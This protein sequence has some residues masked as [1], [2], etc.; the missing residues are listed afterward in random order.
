[1]AYLKAQKK[2]YK[3]K[4][5]IHYFSRVS[6][7][8][9]NKKDIYISLN[10]TDIKEARQ[11]HQEVEKNEKA[12]KD[13]EDVQWSWKSDNG[14]T[15][16]LRKILG[17]CVDEWLDAIKVSIRQ[18]SVDR[19][20]CSLNTFI[21]VMGK[22]CPMSAI[23][24]KSIED[25]KRFYLGKHK[26]G[27]IDI[28]LRGIKK[29]LKWSL[30]EEYIKKMPKIKQF[31]KKTPPKYIN[32]V[33]WRKLMRL[34][35]DDYWKNL[36]NLYRDVGSRLKEILEGE[37]DGN[38]LIVSAEDTKS[39]KVLEIPITEEQKGIIQAIHTRRDEYLSNGYKM[40]NFRDNISKIFKRSCKR[41][42]I[43][44]NF[45]CLRHTFA[46]RKYLET[47]DIMLVSK[48]MNHESL[49]PTEQYTKFNIHRLEQDFPMLS[50]KQAQKD[51]LGTKIK[52]TT[53]YQFATSRL[54]N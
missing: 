27:G 14:R 28:N 39:K 48:M 31:N 47:R 40:V 41:V 30:E 8:N 43:D 45:H 4:I 15:K 35:I 44:Y 33:D 6:M 20:R 50:E 51:D 37:I 3:D 46:V 13:G 32:Q 2:T 17:G 11:R 16:I 22:T 19:Y 9:T 26:K 29:F 52:G 23:N 12:V 1:M 25:F 10:T 21:N 49:Q 54:I 7:Y 24:N 5:T 42:G 34:D 38:F 36:W 18:S 53:N